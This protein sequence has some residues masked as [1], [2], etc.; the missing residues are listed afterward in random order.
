MFNRMKLLSKM[1]QEEEDDNDDEFFDDDDEN[2]ILS[3]E[4][5]QQQASGSWRRWSRNLDA[6]PR[7]P[8]KRDHLA[9]DAQ[10]C[11]DYFGPN[12]VYS[13]MHFRRRYVLKLHSIYDVNL[14]TKNDSICDCRFCM[15]PHVFMRLVQA[16]ENVDPYFH[17]KC[18]AYGRA[19]I[20]TLQKCVASIRILAYG[21][22]TD[23]VDEYVH[24]GEYS[25]RESLNHFCAAVINV[26]RQH[27]LC[28]PT[29]EDVARILHRNVQRG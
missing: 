1:W 23:V 5:L 21:V 28:A 3:Y 26:F 18:N 20:S 2:I 19:G 22:P 7:W 4:Y 10:I 27:Y 9:G 13:P 12:P 6:P 8:N 25:A 14:A 16:V 24:I 17:F 11:V 29:P 15:R